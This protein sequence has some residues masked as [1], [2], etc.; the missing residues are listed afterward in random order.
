[1]GFLNSHHLAKAADVLAFSQPVL[2]ILVYLSIVLGSPPAVLTWSLLIVSIAPACM[3]KGAFRRRTP[4]DIPILIFIVGL[5]ISLS[6]SPYR[7]ISLETFQTYM[8]CIV[9]YYLIVFNGLRSAWYWRLVVA[10]VVVLSFTTVVTATFAQQS[11]G[12]RVLPYNE[13]LYD[14]ASKLPLTHNYH[15]TVNTLGGILGVIA[16][17]L[18]GYAILSSDRRDKAVMWVF[19]VLAAVLVVLASSS[20][21]LVAMLAGLAFILWLRWRWTLGIIIPV[22]LIWLWLTFSNNLYLPEWATWL[23][24]H[25]TFIQRIDLWRGSA[26]LIVDHL[27]TGLG[28][29]AW[30]LRSNLQ[31]DGWPVINPHNDTLTLM[32]DAGVLAGVAFIAVI[33]TV[34]IILRRMIRYPAGNPWRA[35]GLA[36]GASMVAFAANGIWETNVTGTL[37][38]IP[39]GD[40]VYR[41]KCL[42]TPTLWILL[43][44]FVV[45]WIRLSNTKRE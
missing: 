34:G 45:A 2:L 31:V 9:A 5:S 43:A 36:I 16:P 14:A 10:I 21:G 7:E 17:G 13:W 1:M 19:G 23:A 22:G 15:L 3:A 33:V 11:P 25:K 27:F 44:L 4:F 35:L 41:Y 40:M 24:P 32:S 20:S 42:A 18:V 28:P 37:L 8:L 6:F 26:Q 12:A 30:F 38:P 29:G 39:V